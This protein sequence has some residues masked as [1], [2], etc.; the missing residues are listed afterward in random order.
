VLQRLRIRWKLVVIFLVP[1]LV[2]LTVGV[3][4]VWSD[5]GD[6]TRA[7]REGRVLETAIALSRLTHE[8]AQ[9][10]SASTL[11]VGS[12]RR[13][14]SEVLQRQRARVDLAVRN[15]RAVEG[16][17][18]STLREPGVR[19]ALLTAQN[20]LEALD[21]H[22]AEVDNGTEGVPSVQAFYTD[23]INELLLVG[24][25]VASEGGTTDVLRG[26]AS[27]IAIG[28]MKAAESLDRDLVLYV[29][30]SGTFNDDLS[31]QLDRA[32]STQDVW[33]LRFLAAATEPQWV[34]FAGLSKRNDVAQAERLREIVIAAGRR[35]EVAAEASAYVTAMATKLDAIRET[36]DQVASDLLSSN[37]A[38]EAGLVRQLVQTVLA[39]AV[40]VILAIA[41]VIV[42]A[43]SMVRPLARLR[44]SAKDVA[45]HKLPGV[46]ERLHSAEQHEQFDPGAEVELVGIH[47]RDEIGEVAKAFDS[48]H[49]AAMRVAAGQA[50]LRKAIGEM[51][52]NLARRNQ[53][54]IDRQIEVIDKLERGEHDANALAELFRLDH[55]ATRLRRNAENLIV[56]SGARATRRW[57]QP[58]PIYDVIRAAAAEVEDY[59]RIELLPTHDLGLS[60]QAV[61]DVVHLLAE[62]VENAASFSSPHTKVHVAGQP[63]PDGYLIEIEDRGLGMSDDEL[64][65]ANERLADPPVIDLSLSRRLGLFV[66]GRLARRHDIRVW[67]QHSWYGGVTA[68]VLLPDVLL[69]QPAGSV[70]A[71]QQPDDGQH[72]APEPRPALT[73]I[74]PHWAKDHP[75]RVYIPLRRHA[76]SW[77]ANQPL[78]ARQAGQPP[79]APAV[80]S[81]ASWPPAP[82]PPSQPPPSPPQPRPAVAAE[83]PTSPGGLPRRVPRTR[84]DGGQAD[85]KTPASPPPTPT[86]ERSLE[87]VRA[88]L[89]SYQS[90]L[91]RAREHTT[92]SPAPGPVPGSV[93]DPFPT[94]GT[95]DEPDGHNG[96]GT[97]G[98][99]GEVRPT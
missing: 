55:L 38:L 74:G 45:A 28:Q 50:A 37:R 94:P 18:A 20:R 44:D 1:A 41:L 47:T 61:A 26:A 9:E 85:A 16:D 14:G 10:R 80:H 49:L 75:E 98:A 40:V 86:G 57:R 35:G 33:R 97:P 43:R 4:R 25:Q 88:A 21:D 27:L 81:A 79:P 59:R 54:L 68:L 60:G 63:M 32:Q 5:L 58:V 34:S 42:L 23:R 52:M 95:G 8:L 19:S 64:L 6:I 24:A 12:E 82:A 77:A 22:R 3:G 17:I 65:E 84:A 78:A 70:L 92:G 7:N 62:L 69:S 96:S 72:P 15:L 46:V 89:S 87:D 31:Q 39:I 53:T 30:R 51:Y 56:L 71:A 36:E 11:F 93:S 48:A 73:G 67:L 76:A 2:L 83:P 90:G 66:V 29:I 91:R 13:E 99:P